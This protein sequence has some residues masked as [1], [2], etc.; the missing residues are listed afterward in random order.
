MRFEIKLIKYDRAKFSLESFRVEAY[1]C[2]LCGFLSHINDRAAVAHIWHLIQKKSFRIASKLTEELSLYS[3]TTLRSATFLARSCK[4]FVNPA[5]CHGLS[6]ILIWKRKVLLRA[7]ES[8]ER[9]LPVMGQNRVFH[10][11][12]HCSRAH[13]NNRKNFIA[14]PK[15][16][17]QPVFQEKTEEIDGRNVYWNSNWQASRDTWQSVV[18]KADHSSANWIL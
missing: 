5:K 7:V 4:F 14:V 2:T 18:I 1:V 15:F 10:P 16:E 9:L 6:R 3:R 17:S 11:A 8:A 12:W 13:W